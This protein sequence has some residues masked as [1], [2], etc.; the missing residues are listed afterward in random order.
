MGEIADRGGQHSGDADRQPERHGGRA[1]RRAVMAQPQGQRHQQADEEGQSGR[2]RQHVERLAL[3]DHAPEGPDRRSAAQHR[4]QCRGGARGP[5]PQIK[6]EADKRRQQHQE[7][8]FARGRQRRETDAG[9]QCHFRGDGPHNRKPGKAGA[10]QH[11]T[12]QQGKQQRCQSGLHHR[13]IKQA[14]HPVGSLATTCRRVG[15]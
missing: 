14:R 10:L 11:T 2:Q 5:G 9:A 13:I 7:Q 3:G 15:P 12:D 4:Q 6:R 8:D 1:T